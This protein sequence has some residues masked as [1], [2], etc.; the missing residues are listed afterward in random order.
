MKTDTKPSLKE[1]I[2]RGSLQRLVRLPLTVT[3]PETGEIR[4]A[5]HINGSAMTLCGFCDCEGNEEHYDGATTNCTSCIA[6]IR[7]VLGWAG[8]KPNSSIDPT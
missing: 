4:H 3:I 8:K 7:A 2:G 1:E 5:P 6:L